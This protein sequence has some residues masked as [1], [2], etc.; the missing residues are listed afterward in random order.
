M[1]TIFNRL[2]KSRPAEAKIEPPYENHPQLL[3]D[4]LL[5]HWTNPN[6][7]LRDIRAYAPNSIR[8]EEIAISSAETLARHG[9]LT[10]LNAHRHDRRVW[11]IDRKPVIHPIVPAE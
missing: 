10:E 3:L 11:R 7:C 4:W 6:I 1:T 8:D 5:Q 2:S 9:W